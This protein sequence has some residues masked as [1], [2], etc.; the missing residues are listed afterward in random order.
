MT[1]LSDQLPFL[2]LEST[3]E[4][5]KVGTARRPLQTLPCM[6]LNKRPNPIT[7]N[8]SPLDSMATLKAVEPMTPPR[9]PIRPRYQRSSISAGSITLGRLEEEDTQIHSLTEVNK[10]VGRPELTWEETIP[11]PYIKTYKLEDTS[12]SKHAEYGRGAWSVVFRAHEIDFTPSA[13][14]TPPTSPVSEVPGRSS[15][16]VLAVKSPSRRDAHNILHHEARILTYLHS[17]HQASPF[18]VPFHGYDNS[19]HSIIL[20]PLPLNLDSHVRAVAASARSSFSTRTMF[21]PVINQSEWVTLATQLISGLGF[22]HGHECIHG[23]IKPANVLLR[24]TSSGLYEPLYCDFS[25]SRHTHDPAP[26]EITAL[27]PDYT[28]PELLSLLRTPGVPTLPTFPA[29]VYALGVT[30]LFAAIG[31][32]PYAGAK[33][34]IMKLSM[35]KEGRPMDFAM[36]GDQG[37]RVRKGGRVERC[38]V[39]AVKNER[40]RWKVEEWMEEIKRI[41]DE[42]ERD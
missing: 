11:R 14:P 3:M 10:D 21:D 12:P 32:S 15:Q 5:T 35:A 40:E 16:A 23:D 25:S 18:L 1:G 28:A 20:D 31:E 39:G 37:V 36:G 33:M 38:L 2:S 17:F 24:Y 4:L 13:L 42:Q 27:T 9:T 6:P 29:D 26:T 22:L 19:T 34:E 8:S 30:L 41:R 7:T